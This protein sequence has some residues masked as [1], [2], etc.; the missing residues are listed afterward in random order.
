MR[1]A[2]A[3]EL[4]LVGWLVGW[5]AGW[6]VGW[7]AGWLVGWLAGYLAGWFCCMAL[8][9][10]SHSRGS[11]DVSSFSPC[12]RT[13]VEEVTSPGLLLRGKGCICRRGESG[14]CSGRKRKDHCVTQ[15]AD[16]EIGPKKVFEPVVFADSLT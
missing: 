4:A 9:L 13:G 2:H 3:T 16:L 12:P 14:S 1:F 15:A 10:V 5:L 11:N 6:L 7:L 8:P